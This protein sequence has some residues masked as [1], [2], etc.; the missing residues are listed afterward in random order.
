MVCPNAFNEFS[1]VMFSLNVVQ[2]ESGSLLSVVM[3]DVCRIL[4][5][6]S[7]WSSRVRKLG[8]PG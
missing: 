8:R 3:C 2:C 5:L 4:V 7:T 6:E 1:I